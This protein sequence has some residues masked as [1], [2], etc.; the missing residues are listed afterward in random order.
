M[1]NSLENLTQYIINEANAEAQKLLEE[2]IENA[3]TERSQATDKFDAMFSQQKEQ[4]EL[5]SR[6]RIENSLRQHAD[7]QNKEKTQF[8]LKLIGQLFVETENELCE[9]PPDSFLKFFRSSLERLNLRG[10][11][12]VILGGITA[13]KLSDEQRRALEIKTDMYSISI[14][15]K[16][17]P[18]QGGFILEQPPIEYSFLF[19]D[20]LNEIRQ[21]ESSAL[22]KRLMN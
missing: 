11:Y 16:M 17:I 18:N 13:Q 3:R 21:K 9:M 22:L 10:D 7:K 20:M 19:A 5:Q 4:L 12:Q 8:A 15:G 6:Q 1:V 2:A 14:A